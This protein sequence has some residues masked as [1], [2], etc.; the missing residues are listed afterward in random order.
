MTCAGLIYFSFKYWVWCKL[1]V[2]WDLLSA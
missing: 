2:L 1:K